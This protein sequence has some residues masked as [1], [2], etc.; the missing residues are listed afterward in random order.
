MK[1]FRREYHL[2]PVE[3][4]RDTKGH[5]KKLAS[6]IDRL[7]TMVSSLVEQLGYV[8]ALEDF[9]TEYVTLKKVEPQNE[10]S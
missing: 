9:D 5:I 7:E 3:D 6:R 10:K 2:W 8:I 4:N 1:I